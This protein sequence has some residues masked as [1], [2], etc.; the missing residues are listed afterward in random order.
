MHLEM[1]LIEAEYP[2]IITDKSWAILA[3]EENVQHLCTTD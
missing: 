1:A 2:K 3:I